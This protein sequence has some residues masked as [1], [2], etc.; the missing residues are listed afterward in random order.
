MGSSRRSRLPSGVSKNRITFWQ[1]SAKGRALLRFANKEEE[2]ARGISS[3]FWQKNA[4]FLPESAWAERIEAE[5]AG[6]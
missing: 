3:L 6:G 4:Q 5:G 1:P 2:L